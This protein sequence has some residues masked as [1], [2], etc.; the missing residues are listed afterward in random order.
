MRDFTL[1]EKLRFEAGMRY[2]TA[3]AHGLAVTNKRPAE[4]TVFFLGYVFQ[5]TVDPAGAVNHT[6]VAPTEEP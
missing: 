1:A 6:L 4:F 3:H 5:G 2:A